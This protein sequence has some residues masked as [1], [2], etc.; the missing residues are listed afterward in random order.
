MCFGE[1]LMHPLSGL[2]QM[3]RDTDWARLSFWAV[4]VLTVSGWD[5]I[6][7]IDHL[8]PFAEPEPTPA[9]LAERLAPVAR[10]RLTEPTPAEAVVPS[11]PEPEPWPE[12]VAEAGP[13]MDPAEPPQSM[14]A[15]EPAPAKP[16]PP[17]SGR[18]AAPPE[19]AAALA[20]VE[21]PTVL[22]LLPPDPG[23]QGA[24]P[25]PYP[26]AQPPGAAYPL[27][28]LSTAARLAAGALKPSGAR[29][30]DSL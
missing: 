2:L 24:Y 25:P 7:L 22:A 5:S 14:V 26:S 23:W 18:S 21:A 10:V 28:A 19:T 9:E 17:A 1:P 3:P 15:P 8:I 27:S 20:I 13:G 30:H 6:Y 4:V 11:R 29:G 16:T 12:P